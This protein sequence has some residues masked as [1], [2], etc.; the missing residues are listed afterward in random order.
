MPETLVG[1]YMI[2]TRHPQRGFLRKTPLYIITEKATGAKLGEI[3]WYGPWRGFC[4][5]APGMTAVFDRGC[6]FQIGEW[7]TE[8]NAAWKRSKKEVP[9]GQV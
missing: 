3:Q 8:L 6:L 1:K 9:D 2:A 7:L 4:Y 5:Y